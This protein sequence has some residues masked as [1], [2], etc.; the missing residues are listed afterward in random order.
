MH[1]TYGELLLFS[2]SSTFGAAMFPRLWMLFEI[3]VN[4]LP[5]TGF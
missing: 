1:V 4:V 3:N 5:T 2:C